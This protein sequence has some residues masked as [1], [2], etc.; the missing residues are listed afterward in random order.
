M[1]IDDLM[2]AYIEKEKEFGADS[3]IAAIICKLWTRI[4]SYYYKNIKSVTFEDCMDWAT[5]SIL[6]A[7]RY[8]RW[9]DPSSQMYNDPKG[10][11]K[12]INVSMKSAQQGFYQ[13]SNKP[14]RKINYAID[15]IDRISSLM[16]GEEFLP[17]Q[18]NQEQYELPYL[19]IQKYYKKQ[20]LFNIFVIS[21]ILLSPKVPKQENLD[22]KILNYLQHL[23]ERVVGILSYRYF[24][25]YDIMYKEY[26]N[27]KNYSRY[28]LL[29]KIN[30]SLEKIKDDIIK[31]QEE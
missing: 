12:S 17:Y 14:K 8:R 13:Y 15:S 4:N 22:R 2:N 24:L 20:N 25:D 30:K 29:K 27:I 11:S 6:S 23:N 31:L 21:A 5:T 1:S 19:L 9:L 26:T 7:L 16:N 3:Y 18:L 10:P 28:V